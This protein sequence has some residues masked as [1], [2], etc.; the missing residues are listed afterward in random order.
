MNLFL[1]ASLTSSILTV[2]L[3]LATAAIA[4]AIVI[5]AVRRNREQR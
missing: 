5:T 4:F 3:P 1:A 2:V